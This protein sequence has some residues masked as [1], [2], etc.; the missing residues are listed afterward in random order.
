MR[1]CNHADLRHVVLQV[2]GVRVFLEMRAELATDTA[3]ASAVSCVY[4]STD[5]STVM[6]LSTNDLAHIFGAAVRSHCSMADGAAW[7]MVQGHIVAEQQLPL[8]VDILDELEVE[9]T[10]GQQQRTSGYCNL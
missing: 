8:P 1:P 10:E 2:S 5:T 9:Q 7:L 6:R 4:T 3:W